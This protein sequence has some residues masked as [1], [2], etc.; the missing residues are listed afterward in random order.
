MFL[1]YLGQ[2][3]KSEEATTAA[4]MGAGLPLVG[5]AGIHAAVNDLQRHHRERLRG[6]PASV[7]T[8]ISGMRKI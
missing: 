5:R 8:Q 2:P 3:E 4:T 6:R 1:L 7:R